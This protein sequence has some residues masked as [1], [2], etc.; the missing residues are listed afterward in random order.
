[1][2]EVN[3][4]TVAA[5]FVN[6]TETNTVDSLTLLSG[7]ADPGDTETLNGETAARWSGLASLDV[8]DQTGMIVFTSRQELDYPDFAGMSL[9]EICAMPTAGCYGG[10]TNT[11]GIEFIRGTPVSQAVTPG[12]P[13][14]LE[15]V[16]LT[17]LPP[18]RR[19]SNPPS[20]GVV[21][22]HRS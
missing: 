9:S 7:P 1:M 16:E 10:T 3:P 20:Y 17:T 21:R 14:V 19:H 12:G 13:V 15:T 4:R 6:Q 18:S 8:V 22:H 2:P 11:S 5:L